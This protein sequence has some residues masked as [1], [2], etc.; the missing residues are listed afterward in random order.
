MEKANQEKNQLAANMDSFDTGNRQETYAMT[1]RV[2][3]LKE[4]LAKS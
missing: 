1:E 2:S 4:D 3:K